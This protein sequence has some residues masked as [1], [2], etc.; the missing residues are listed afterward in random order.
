MSKMISLPEINIK[1]NKLLN[2]PN[3]NFFIIMNLVLIISCYTFINTQLRYSISSFLSNPLII[4]FSLI[5]VII[6]GYHNINVAIMIL[7]VFFVGLYSVDMKKDSNTIETFTDATDIADSDNNNNN[8]RK[9]KKKLK[10]EED[11]NQIKLRK[12]IIEDT[13]KTTDERV[14][15]IKNLLLGSVKKINND[16]ENDYKKALLDNKKLM[17]ENEKR[18]HK[19]KDEE[20]NT[21]NKSGKSNGSKK[22]KEEFQTIKTRSFDPGNEEDTNLLITKEILQDMIKRIEYNFETNKYLKRY[23]RQRIEEIVE[24]NNLLEDED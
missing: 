4:L 8:N 5:L 3:I 19:S 20:D 18:K 7:F 9:N 15:S 2:N 6:I 10:E 14:D 21:N 11:L 16:N 1:I 23:L 12:K 22:G 13:E 24:L 17:Y